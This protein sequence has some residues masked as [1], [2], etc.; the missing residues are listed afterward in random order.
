QA[1]IPGC[2]TEVFSRQLIVNTPP[3][4]DFDFTRVCAGLATTLINVIPSNDIET[5]FWDFSDGFTSNIENPTHA[6]PSE[7]VYPV[8][9]TVTDVNGCSNSITK[10]VQVGQIPQPEISITG[11][12]ACSETV[13]QFND[14]TDNT[15][16]NTTSRLWSIEG[17]EPV[18]DEPNPTFTFTE[19]GDY[20]LSLT[21]ENDFGCVATLDTLITVITSPVANFDVNVACVGEITSFIDQTSGNPDSWFWVINGQQ[22]FDQNPEVAFESPGTYEVSLEVTADNFCVATA[23]QT[24]EVLATP[25]VDFSIS[26]NCT[27]E[28]IRFE[29]MSQVLND[30][31]VSRQWDFGDNSTTNGAVTFHQYD[32][33][34]NYNVTLRLVTNAGCEVSFTQQLIVNQ[35]PEAAFDVVRDF[36]IPPFNIEATDNSTDASQIDWYLNDQ[37]LAVND[38]SNP[39][40]PITNEGLFT[41]RQVVTNSL[42]CKDSTEVS[43]ISGIPEYD[44]ILTDFDVID[45]NGNSSLVISVLNNSNLPMAGFD[46][47]VAIDN[48]VII[49][50]RYT[51]IIRQ[52]EQIIYTLNATLPRQNLGFVCVNVSPPI[53]EF[54]D[55][56]LSNN[57]DCRNISNRIEVSAA[58]PNPT[59]S[60]AEIDVV[61]DESIPFDFLLTDLSGNTIDQVSFEASESELSRVRIDLQTLS[62]GMYLVVFNFNGEKIVRR[63]LK[64]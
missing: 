18:E 55:Y 53:A 26:S 50:E 20:P 23:T 16:S 41:L 17:F 12:L 9:F 2:T 44:L 33:P 8:S 38:L 64:N 22:Y 37:F 3:E 1:I 40:I 11:D 48:Q 59:S 13:L 7:G 21:I 43:I 15:V 5:Y 27:S 49:T 31:V 35:S 29:D 10:N 45:N 51:E 39:V 47:N 34:G 6:F 32:Q 24:F 36:G 63:I 62:K 14:I 58:Y 60:F 25:S 30:P 56:N 4:I 54:P 42:G 28:Q 57:E 61:L 46:V 19:S 52:A